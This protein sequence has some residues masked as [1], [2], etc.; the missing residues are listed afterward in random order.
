MRIAIEVCLQPEGDHR[1]VFG[2]PETDRAAS[3]TQPK[4]RVK[5][6]R[7]NFHFE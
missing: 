5:R 7:D 6:G 3:Q 1:A 4:A 2:I